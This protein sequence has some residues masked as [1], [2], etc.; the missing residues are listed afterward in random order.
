LNSC[1]QNDL[2][3]KRDTFEKKLLTYCIKN[4]IPV[5]GICE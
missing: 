5:F 2:S 3:Q 4:K 1:S